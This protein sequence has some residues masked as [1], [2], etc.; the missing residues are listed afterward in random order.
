MT[1]NDQT[2]SGKYSCCRL[3]ESAIK[4]EL[5]DQSNP[6][7]RPPVSVILTHRPFRRAPIRFATL[8]LLSLLPA[9]AALAQ[10]PAPAP[11]KTPDL[12]VFTNGEQLTGELEKATGDGITFKSAMAGE[13][14]VPWKNIQTLH[15]SKSFAILTAKQKLTRKDALALVPQGDITAE[16]KQITVTN[17]AGVKKTIPVADASLL[18]D[19]GDFGKAVDHQPNLLHGWGG[20][21]TGGVTLI[22]ATQDNTTF[23][24][25]ITLTRATP[26]VDWLP[27][28]D[29][30][31]LNYTQS[32]GTVS[33]FG[34]PTVET[35][36]FHASFERDE[37]FSPR[38][39][40]FGSTTF[41]HNFSSNLDLQQAYGGGVGITLIKNSKQQVDF[42]GDVHYEKEVF[43]DN[44]N[45][46]IATAQNQN[47]FGSTFSENLVR[48]L[49]KKG[50]VFNEFGSYS[51]A[52]SQSNSSPTQ[53]NA[54]SA[55]ANASFIF[56][57]YKG[58][59][60]NLGA[61]D[62][63]INNAPLGSKKNSTQYTTGITYTIKPR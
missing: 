27:A 24:G 9:A 59:A 35:N 60:F 49:N 7:N 39:F 57:V 6:A 40:A 29:R 2:P 13:I 28:H 45:S 50:L 43:F 36:I 11:A 5:P 32:Y 16:D 14:N 3:G 56:P 33:Q 10:T 41:D 25:A 20:T 21:A 42:K 26:N 61:V 52:W 46:L 4:P 30:T 22:R 47:I 18:V 37:Y 23:N 44:F 62:D 51:P 17:A 58:F 19:S 1:E 31:I 38:L 12:V 53:P 63:F 15:S 54:F 8:L 48:H 55:H 34:T